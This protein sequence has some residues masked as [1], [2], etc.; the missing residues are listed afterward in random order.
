MLLLPEVVTSKDPSGVFME[1]F[2]LF[3]ISITVFN[4]SFPMVVSGD[5]GVLKLGLSD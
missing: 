2:N 3:T 5:K 4:D 1:V